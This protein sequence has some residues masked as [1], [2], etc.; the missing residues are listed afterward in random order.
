[1]IMATAAAHNTTTKSRSASSD[2]SARGEKGQP[3]ADKQKRE[4]GGSRKRAS[5]SNMLIGLAIAGTAIG[6]GILAYWKNAFEALQGEDEGPAA[7]SRDEADPEN[8]DQTRSAGPDAMRD[9]N[10]DDWD[11]VDQAAD[12][13]FPASDPPGY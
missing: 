3:Q 1:M 6:I 7:F 12:E 9:D 10:G 8:F 11:K 4:N 5:S 2:K 13:S